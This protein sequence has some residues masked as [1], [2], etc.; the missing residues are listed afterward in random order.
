[1]QLNPFKYHSDEVV[2]FNYSQLM[3][4]LCV[5]VEDLIVESVHV[6]LHGWREDGEPILLIGGVEVN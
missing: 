3:G 1:M 2:E 4:A 5:D 6:S